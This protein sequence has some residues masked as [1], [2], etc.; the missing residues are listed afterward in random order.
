[1]GNESSFSHPEYGRWRLGMY[2]RRIPGLVDT[3]EYFLIREERLNNGLWIVS[4]SQSDTKLLGVSERGDA[5][6]MLKHQGWT[7]VER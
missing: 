5:I 1:M 7:R 4:G 3:R 2:L 6:R